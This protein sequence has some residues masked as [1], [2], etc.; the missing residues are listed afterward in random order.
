MD[1]VV[2]ECVSPSRTSEM[3]RALKFRGEVHA[4]Q[5]VRACRLFGSAWNFAVG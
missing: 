3:V 4:S 2:R 1:H 5:H